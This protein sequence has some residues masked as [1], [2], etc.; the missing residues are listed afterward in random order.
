LRE[1]ALRLLRGHLAHRPADNPFERFGESLMRELPGLRDGGEESYHAY[2][3]A[4]VRMAGSG[5]ELAAAH[6]DWLLG[7]DAAPAVAGFQEVVDG[8]KV[9]SFRL[10][11]RRPF[12]AW[13]IL[14][15]LAY[16]WER[17]IDAAAKAAG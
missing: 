11:R 5:F 1:H 9:L 16:A 3:F 7:A 10:A 12:D 2:A 8:C 13:P 6:L 15:P 4:T 17:A 14:E